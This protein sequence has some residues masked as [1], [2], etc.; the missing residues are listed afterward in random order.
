MNL[1][2]FRH[3][4]PAIVFAYFSREPCRSGVFRLHGSIFNRLL[5]HSARTTWRATVTKWTDSDDRYRRRNWNS[6]T[7][8]ISRMAHLLKRH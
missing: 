2:R 5:R 4:L 7:T 8:T 3:I 1:I 6:E